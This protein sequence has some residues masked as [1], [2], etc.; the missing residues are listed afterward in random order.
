MSGKLG[1]CVK[2]REAFEHR[3]LPHLIAGK[4]HLAVRRLFWSKFR[5][6]FRYP[7]VYRGNIPDH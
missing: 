5:Q 7:E 3:F 6:S 4:P 1:D 2:Q